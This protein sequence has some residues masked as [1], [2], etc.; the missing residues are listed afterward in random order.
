MTKTGAATA[1]QPKIANRMW[2]NQSNAFH[3]VK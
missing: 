1:I 3:P 2:K